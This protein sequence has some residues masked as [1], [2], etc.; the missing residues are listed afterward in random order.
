MSTD[1]AEGMNEAVPSKRPFSPPLR[2]VITFFSVQ[3]PTR[4][5]LNC[6]TED[7]G[8]RLLGHVYLHYMKDYFGVQAC[9]S[10]L[11]HRT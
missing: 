1:G 2:N 3:E 6:S 11:E 4:K 7:G 9:S 10:L 8:G 5:L